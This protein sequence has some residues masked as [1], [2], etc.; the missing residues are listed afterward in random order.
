MWRSLD[1]RHVSALRHP[2][3][4]RV[5]DPVGERFVL[6]EAAQ[7]F[8]QGLGFQLIGIL[9]VGESFSADYLEMRQNGLLTV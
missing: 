8:F 1:E 6:A 5:P 7:H 3:N 4:F 2:A 9:D